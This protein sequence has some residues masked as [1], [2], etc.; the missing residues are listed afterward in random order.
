M[1]S[2][3]RVRALR[4]KARIRAR[5]RPDEALAAAAEKAERV[6]GHAQSEDARA[7]FGVLVEVYRAE[8]ERR[9]AVR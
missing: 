7:A 6:A 1:L 9:R 8:L 3:D 4:S 2:D 5:T